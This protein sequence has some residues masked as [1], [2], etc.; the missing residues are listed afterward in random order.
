[1]T[2]TAPDL[3]A[4][5]QHME[6]NFRFTAP[7]AADPVRIEQVFA[8]R[9]GGGLVA[10]PDTD[11]PPTTP[12]AWDAT[13]EK[14]K[15]LG[16]FDATG[17]F[18]ASTTTTGEGDSAVTTTTTPDFVTGAWVYA[19]RGDQLVRLINGANL[20]KETAVI[21]AD[22]AALIPTIRLV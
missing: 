21:T 11:L 10:N 7:A 16:T 15:V 20:R 18:T 22:Q 4:E 6:T 14:F 3:T 9:P 2:N 19:G 17:K 13:S 1:M 8:E 5:L 12:V